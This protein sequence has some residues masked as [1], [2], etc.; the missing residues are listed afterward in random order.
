MWKFRYLVKNNEALN[1]P[2]KSRMPF[3]GKYRRNFIAEPIVSSLLVLLIP[4]SLSS[5]V[6]TLSIVLSRD[7]GQM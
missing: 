1:F 4:F 7:L 6:Q 2:V 5:A 3:I